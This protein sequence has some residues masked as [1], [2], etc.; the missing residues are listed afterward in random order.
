MHSQSVSTRAKL[1]ILACF[2]ACVA[3]FWW[4]GSPASPAPAFAAGGTVTVCDYAT[5][6]AQLT[7]APAGGTIA[8]ACDGTITL[9]G[10][11]IAIAANTTLDASGHSVTFDAGGAS[12]VF[13]VDPGVQLTLVN[14]TVT[15]GSAADGGGIANNGGTVTLNRTTL[16]GNAATASGGAI[17]NDGG[18]VTLTNST[19]SGNSAASGGAIYNDGGTITLNNSTIAS[20]SGGGLGGTGFALGN[21]IVANNGGGNCAAPATDQ[22][23]NLQ[24][25]GTTCGGGIASADPLLGTLALNAP[26]F[27]QT[28]AIA[29]DSPA[30][31]AGN[32]AT[33]ASVDQRGVTR[34]QPTGGTCDIGAYEAQLPALT[35]AY[36]APSIPLDAT[37]TLTFTL[38]SGAGYPAFAGTLSFTDTLD[39]ALSVSP[40][41][42]DC[43][44]SLSATGNTVTLTGGGLGAGPATCTISVTVDP[45]SVGTFTNT[46]ANLSGVSNLIVSGVDATLTVTAAATSTA[47]TTAPNPSAFG[48]TVTITATVTSGAGTPTGTVEFFDGAASLGTAALDAGGQASITVDTL[49]AG[50]HTITAQFAGNATFA[51]STSPDHTHDVGLA[52]TS[53]SVTTAPNPSAFG[54]LVTIT[55]TVTSGAGTPAG[56]VEFF[57]GAASLGTAA[58]DAGGQASITTDTLSAGSHTITA[59]YLGGGAF[60]GSTSPD[61]T[62]DVGQIATTTALSASPNPS[63][64]GQPV[65]LTATVT[66]SSGTPT[67]TVE[68]FD[69]ATSLGTVALDA[70]GQ[71]VL[72]TSALPVGT[73]SLTAEYAGD[74]AYL[75]STSTAIT[76]TVNPQLVTCDAATFAGLL[77]TTPPGSTITFGCDGTITLAGTPFTVASSVILD[78]TGRSVTFDGDDLSGVFVVSPGVSLTVINLTITGGAAVDGGAIY[79]NGG[80]IVLGSGAAITGNA[81]T[82]SGGGV[83]L[84]G[85]GS[86]LTLNSGSVVS[87]NTAQD[88]GGIASQGGAVTVQGGADVTG[89]TATGKGGGIFISDAPLIVTGSGTLIGGAAGNTAQ[90][91]G[92]VFS[93]G[94]TASVALSGGADVTGNA[95]TGNGGGIYN[96]SAAL[97]ITGGGTTVSGNS[98]TVHGGGVFNLTGSVLLTAGA[99]IDGNSTSTGNGGGLYN[100]GGPATIEDGADMTGNDA[101][102]YGG[103]IYSRGGGLV[104]VTGSGTLIGGAAGNTA[105]D[106]GGG[107]YS[108]GTT[109]ELIVSGGSD[110]SGNSVVAGNGG[111]IY[112]NLGTLTVTGSGTTIGGS[113]G[114]AASGH[115][116]GILN[117]AGTTSVESGALVSNNTAVFGGGIFNYAVGATLTIQSG[118]DVSGNTAT[119]NGGGIYNEFGAVTVTGSGTNIGGSPGNSAGTHGGGILNDRGTLTIEGG[120]LVSN[121]SATNG[122]GVYNYAITESPSTVRVQTGA[123]VAG[124]TA[125]HAGGGIYNDSGAIFVEGA[126]TIIGGSTGNTATHGGGVYNFGSGATLTVNN[127]ARIDNNDASNGGGI[128]NNGGAVTVARSTIASNTATQ[129]GGGINATSGTLSAIQSTISGNSAA[130]GGGLYNDGAGVTVDNSTISGNSAANGGGLYNAGGSATLTNVTVAGNTGNGSGVNR[131]GGTVTVRN[132]IL[133]NGGTNCAGTISD[134]SGNLQY[135]G[136]SC[137]G[138][139]LSRDPLLGPLADNSGATFTHLPGAGSP[140][141]DGA[142]NAHCLAVDQR[143]VVRSDNGSYIDGDGDTIGQCDAGS[144]EVGGYVATATCAG[145]T[146]VTPAECDALVAL[147]SSANGGGWTESTGWTTAPGTTPEPCG[148]FGVTCTAGAPRRVIALELPGNGLSGSIPPELGDL[149]ALETLDLSGNALIGGIPASLGDPAS[150]VSLDLSGNGLGGTIPASLGDLTALQVLALSDNQIGGTIPSRLGN[151]SALE[152]L[153]LDRNRLSGPIPAS[154]GGLSALRTLA[155]DNNALQGDLPPALANLSL[156]GTGKTPWGASHRVNLRFNRLSASDAGVRGF[157]NQK[158]PGWAGTQTV[159][160]GGVRAR[161]L[162]ASSVV[163]SWGPIAYTNHGGGYRVGYSTTPGEPYTFGCETG[164][165]SARSCRIDGLPA[166]PAYYFAVQSFTPAHGDQQNDLLSAYS[167]EVVPGPAAPAL[168]SP[169]HRA[170]MPVDAPSFAWEGVANGNTYEFQLD[171]SQGFGTPEQA[172]VRTTTGF[173][174]APLPDGR[175][176]WRVRAV[177]VNGQPS[178]WSRAWQVIIDTED[179]AAPV[180][181]TPRDRSNT[182]DHTPRLNWRAVPGANIYQVRVYNNP[183]LSGTPL[184]DAT[185]PRAF[186]VVP[187]ADALGFGAAY[188]Q[189]RAQDHAGNW[190]PWSEVNAFT[191]T[192]LKAPTN[193]AFA[194]SA[195]PVFRWAREPGAA[196][197]RVQIDT[198]AG[199]GAPRAREA[200]VTSTRYVPDPPL[201]DGTY[202]WRVSPDGGATWTPGWMLTVTPGPLRA[203]RPT[204]PANGLVSYS[205]TVELAWDALAGASEYQVQID[206]RSNFTAPERDLMS[207][208]TTETLAGLADG[209]Y[210][211]RVRAFNGEGVAG[212][213]SSK[214]SFVIKTDAPAL[215]SPADRA[216]TADTTPALRWR[217]HQGAA[218]YHARIA[219]DAACTTVVRED[220]AHTTRRYVPDPA[221]P[222]GQYTWCVRA[223]D[224]LGTWSPWSVPFRLTVIDAPAKPGRPVLQSPANGEVT[225]DTTP[226]FT[227]DA[228]PDAASYQ[229]QLDTNRRFAAPIR[230]A[231]PGG[232]SHTPGAA[233]PDGAYFWRVRAVNA[234]L[235]AGAWSAPRR[236]IVDTQPPEVP[237]PK[238]PAAGSST[239]DTTPRFSWARARDARLYHV[240]IASN[241]A[242]T[243]VVQ[244]IN[245]VPRL[246]AIP[247]TALDYGTYFW[248]VRA[249]DAAGNLGSWS[250]ATPFHVTILKAPNDDASV[251]DTT[252]TLRWA[253][254]DGVSSYDVQIDDTDLTFNSLVVEETVAGQTYTA[255]PLAYGE[256]FWRVSADGGATWMP[257][258]RL[259]VTPG[260]PA[261]P[262]PV[263]PANRLLAATDSLTFGWQA[264][265]N[266]ATYELHIDDDPRF[267]SPIA[268]AVGPNR[269]QQ[270]AASLPEGVLYWRVRALNAFGAPGPW[271]ARRTL[272]IDTTPPAAPDPIAP[273]DN[274]RVTNRRLKL[275]WTRAGDADRYLVE[276]EAGTG[277]TFTLPPV[278][279]GSRPSYQLPETLA[280]GTYHWRVYAV[281]RAGNVSAASDPRHFSL[282]AGVTVLGAPTGESAITAPEAGAEPALIRIESD[283]PAI[284][285]S[286]TW[287]THATGA[288][289]GGSYRYSSGSAGD[290]LSLAFEG[291]RAEVIIVRNPAL[292]VLAVELDGTVLDLIDGAAPV[293]EFGVRIALEGLAAGPHTLRVL[294]SEGTIAVDAFAV[295]ALVAPAASPTPVPFATPEETIAPPDAP[296]ATPGLPDPSGTPAPTVAPTED[297][298]TVTPTQTPAETPTEPPTATTT[299]APTDT[300]TVEP[301]SATPTAEPSATPTATAT[302][303]DE[304]PTEAPGETVPDAPPGAE[305]PGESDS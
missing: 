149:F 104:T 137:G 213:W 126:G 31:D 96:D 271:S 123:D 141:I 19:L 115:G 156:L 33:C 201:D 155:L 21:T 112:N 150:L 4:G 269:L 25:P 221:L 202:Y 86:S 244:A 140:A 158:N 233:L 223:Q 199:F 165:K 173:T 227:W 205:T 35:K 198:D 127:Q 242:C 135:P 222:A 2:S 239:A 146:Q 70:G 214:R 203:P 56:T 82:G 144:V 10:S 58:L 59:Q 53:T 9:P 243:T 267:G 277:T 90:N 40:G 193:G 138:G 300:P 262:R 38:T 6:E 51:G 153:A 294:A 105:G 234:D 212:Q 207:G 63:G 44:G 297:A 103:A 235:I 179:P 217:N 78:G 279:A 236:V 39:L 237:A 160:P 110:V 253:A 229:F 216:G 299:P 65:T 111:G 13:T 77:A 128:R 303:G 64:Y 278:D 183:A 256:Y 172:A 50:T 224:A 24:Y 27:T 161:T 192:L 231:N 8:F 176:F 69:D 230:D 187:D 257:A 85:A 29:F 57:D 282:V 100:N 289:S 30:R 43:G 174:T 95:A 81:A 91:G 275:E 118:A 181:A 284:T 220:P 190:G 219:T 16:T 94:E 163:V 46:G 37:T 101:G 264:A 290:A 283:D 129:N 34:P 273:L 238:Q 83:F 287:T 109:S 20:N 210:Y 240:R 250:A 48:E 152:Y 209:R 241:A 268:I 259:I 71:A 106:A 93:I 249:E 186:Y 142:N 136:T 143:D 114:N 204:A 117:D 130:N 166:A 211:W 23:S 121:N 14:L 134:G 99:T 301:P 272:T 32:N 295:E 49:S 280:Q 304:P 270:T 180:L 168:T 191:V 226:T 254:I 54:E 200:T 184:I 251:L 171:N 169:A 12:G 188:W 11:A 178:S 261:R 26:G 162:S 79:A 36:T 232:T 291:T 145:V 98:A 276:V 107:I 164:S 305:D 302:P 215:Q 84:T 55:A 97:T 113:P 151:L 108:Y 52:S 62:H 28:H 177:N 74:A 157:F 131:A 159:P 255:G 89:N 218:L 102:L 182:P 42:S 3:L 67:G 75:G 17:Y 197:Y 252:P 73:R 22:G 41:A 80:D 92:G 88:G 120:A 60:A 274:A 76:Q 147:Y 225:N 288:A 125:S 247:D 5:F 87:G 292:G 15:G 194:T 72:I 285:A 196:A 228:V 246:A 206:D 167:D 248:C 185:T 154:L 1:A 116:G 47:V 122:G 208:D 286:G 61:H 175:Y 68:F 119:A 132:T 18:A 148:W 189:V 245:D 7:A 133:H 66:A 266:A 298:P 293:D 296:T 281:D 139:I 170:V 258:R 195:A 124:N 260:R 263:E 265:A 45:G